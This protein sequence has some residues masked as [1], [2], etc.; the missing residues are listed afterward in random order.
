MISEK[1]A[2]INELA[3]KQKTAGLS[4]E[5]KA[6]QKK[7]REEYIADYRKNFIGILDN[8]SIKNPDGSIIRLKDK[9]VK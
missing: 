9:N 1:I 3:R 7:L 6:E 2:R 4:D 5:E 8:T